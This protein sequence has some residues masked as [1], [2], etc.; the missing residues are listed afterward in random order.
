MDRNARK[1]AQLKSILET[2]REG[3][4][5]LDRVH[6][7]YVVGGGIAVWTY[8]RRRWTKDIDIF[9][10]PEDAGAALDALAGAGFRTEMTDPTWLYK[11]FKA[12]VMVDVIF[13]SKG[14]IFL[15]DEALR[16]GQERSID[17]YSFRFM[18]P[19]DLIIRKIFAMIEERPDWYDGI[20]VLDGLNG[21]LDWAYLL[22]RAQRDPGR[23]LSFLLYAE[24]E[25]PRER[26]LIPSWA[27]RDLAQQVIDRP[28]LYSAA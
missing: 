14:D 27:I 17:G 3:A 16:R 15:D 22:R 8:G 12:D 11:S 21:R 25:Y 9:L 28:S 6:V 1:D 10:R 2:F 23:V 7:P 4:D 13:R 24:S 5:T 19:E 18:A 20:S 26:V